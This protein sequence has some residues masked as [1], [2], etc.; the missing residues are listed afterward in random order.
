MLL[1]QGRSILGTPLFQ[2]YLATLAESIATAVRARQHAGALRFSLQ[3]NLCADL[4]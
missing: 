4:Y 1:E 3:E 2:L